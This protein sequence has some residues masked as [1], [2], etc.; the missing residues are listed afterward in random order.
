MDN[1]TKTSQMSII[2]PNI[3]TANWEIYQIAI[4]ILIPLSEEVLSPN[5]EILTTCPL[6]TETDCIVCSKY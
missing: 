4:V 3:Q 1:V 2:S 6:H 5:L